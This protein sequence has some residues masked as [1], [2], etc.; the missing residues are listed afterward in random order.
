[1]SEKYQW[2]Y[3][4]QKPTDLTLDI[5]ILKFYTDE[6]AIP[7]IRKFLS[8]GVSSIAVFAILN[9]FAFPGKWP[10]SWEIGR[11]DNADWPILFSQVPQE[12]HRWKTWLSFIVCYAKAL[13]ARMLAEDMDQQPLDCQ[14]DS[15]LLFYFW[16]RA[17]ECQHFQ[18]CRPRAAYTWGKYSGLC[19]S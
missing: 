13:S 15:C 8:P 16:L 1:M 6:T 4:N 18:R 3:L 9:E 19:F 11:F 2:T 5:G 7:G 14:L 10:E 12:I 17:L